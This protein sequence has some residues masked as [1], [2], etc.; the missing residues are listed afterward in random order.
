[1]LGKGFAFQAQR[2]RSTIRSARRGIIDA[3][4]KGHCRAMPS[5]LDAVIAGVLAATATMA[6]EDRNRSEISPPQ[7]AKVAF[8]ETISVEMD[9]S[10]CALA[11]ADYR[12]E[13]ARRTIMMA[14]GFAAPDAPSV[15]ALASCGDK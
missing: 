12:D 11:I 13:V 9:S 15:I 8:A 10:A 2:R 4:L 5:R 7:A 1:L 14:F 3:P 6:F